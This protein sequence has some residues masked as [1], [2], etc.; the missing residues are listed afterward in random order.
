MKE[1]VVFATP[2]FDLVAK[3]PPNYDAAHYSIQTLDYVVIVA[4]T[5]QNQLVLVRQFR[6]AVGQTTLEVPA[7]H[8]ELGETPEQAAR[9]ELLEETGF[10]AASFHPLGDF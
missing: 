5:A 7:G 10:Q 4:A 2:W 3:Y 8:V 1:E 9:R 6:P